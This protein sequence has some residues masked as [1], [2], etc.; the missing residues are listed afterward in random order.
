M[1][2]DVQV[3]VVGVAHH[4]VIA[5]REA[6]L[7]NV[8]LAAQY[9]GLSDGVRRKETDKPANLALRPPGLADLDCGEA[10][11]RAEASGESA[12]VLDVHAL[13]AE[14]RVTHRGEVFHDL[15]RKGSVRGG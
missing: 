13:G 8:L 4:R 1:T 14:G 9:R 12:G 3:I 5:L 7:L 2:Q 11:V 15:S 10:R 6:L